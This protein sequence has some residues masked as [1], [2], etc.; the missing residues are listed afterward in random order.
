[1]A[2]R[3]LRTAKAARHAPCP[4]RRRTWTL[5]P[6]PPA[7]TS[8][9]V[10]SRPGCDGRATGC[11][12]TWSAPPASRSPTTLPRS[13]RASR[14]PRPRAERAGPRPV[15]GGPERRAALLQRGEGLAHGAHA[16]LRGR[17]RALGPSGRLLA[18]GSLARRAPLG[19]RIRAARAR[20]PG[21]SFLVAGLSRPCRGHGRGCGPGPGA[22]WALAQERGRD[23]A[24][25]QHRETG[26]GVLALQASGGQGGAKAAVGDRG[27]QRAPQPAVQRGR[28]LRAGP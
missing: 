4:P 5:R 2:F 15:G 20:G 12:P 22:T 23:G 11:E 14:L 10:R 17:R 25:G 7:A 27:E 8:V 3:P 26:I 18:P 6:I 1:M 9:V 21:A 13:R 19:P 16:P 24:A 28:G